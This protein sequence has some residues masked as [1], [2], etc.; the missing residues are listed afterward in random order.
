[1]G[2]DDHPL[3]CPPGCTLHLSPGKI[4][5]SIMH[6]SACKRLRG[7]VRGKRLSES[8]LRV[9][10][11]RTIKGCVYGR[12]PITDCDY[13]LPSSAN[14]RRS[15]RLRSLG[16]IVLRAQP[17]ID[18]TSHLRGRGAFHLARVPT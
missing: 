6:Q 1:M 7:P 4:V 5:D 8:I 3:R 15:I 12:L 14:A 18:S 10:N 9:K 11:A 17:A 2:W 13:S 16:E